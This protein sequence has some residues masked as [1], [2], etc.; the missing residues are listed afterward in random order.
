MR[1]R[2]LI[3]DDHE[4]IRHGLKTLLERTEGWTVCGEASTGRE[5]I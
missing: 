2:I 5:A 4:V 1:A 3:V